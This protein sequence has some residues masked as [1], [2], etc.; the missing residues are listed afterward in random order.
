MELGTTHAHMWSE[1]V[2]MNRDDV[3]YSDA[4]EYSDDST[5]LR[6]VTQ[7]REQ[8]RS[9][10]GS[11]APSSLD[12]G[13]P[14]QPESQPRVP[15]AP[16]AHH[17]PTS[18][19][20][21]RPSTAV[22]GFLGHASQTP[23]VT[24]RQKSRSFDSD[25]AIAPRGL[26]GGGGGGGV[27]AQRRSSGH[28]YSRSWGGKP[29][30]FRG[31]GGGG[32][33][34]GRGQLAAILSTSLKPPSPA[35]TGASRESSSDFDDLKGLSDSERLSLRGSNSDVSNISN[36]DRRT[37]PRLHLRF[38]SGP[39]GAEPGTQHQPPSTQVGDG[40]DYDVQQ[41]SDYA[42]P[43]QDYAMR[44]PR[45]HN[46]YK[47]DGL[48][49]VM[50]GGELGCVA[51]LCGRLLHCFF[52]PVCV[53]CLRY[54][55]PS[56]SLTRCAGCPPLPPPHRRKHSIRISTAGRPLK[57]DNPKATTYQHKCLLPS[58]RHR[59]TFL[60]RRFRSPP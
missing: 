3:D 25:G 53:L 36:Y 8:S 41:F 39:Y 21:A 18:H 10:R 43:P 4:F 17:S 45:A 32:G 26:G 2:D 14:L 13:Q 30:N 28:A 7:L 44:S 54:G 56:S 48:C 33:S 42:Y 52:V 49:P 50:V 19:K 5:L 40:A 46:R 58:L 12:S 34:K 37:H 55:S 15:P 11:A 59:S 6:Q 31:G 51:H 27:G 38:D 35:M 22:T 1:S 29:A 9:R 57:E 23:P 24:Q 16:H 60:T 47:D 20:H